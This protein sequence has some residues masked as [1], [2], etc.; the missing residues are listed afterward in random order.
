MRAA[1]VLARLHICAASPESSLLDNAISTNC[2]CAGAFVSRR[3]K[4]WVFLHVHNIG[5]GQPTH[6]CSLISV[7]VPLSLNGIIHGFLH[8]SFQESK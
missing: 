4:I 8:Q 2:S 6:L 7:I 3:E 1:K 5:A